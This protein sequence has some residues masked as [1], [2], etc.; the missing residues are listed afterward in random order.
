MFKLDK[1]QKIYTFKSK[2]LKKIK[3]KEKYG[4][5]FKWQQKDQEKI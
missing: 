4:G 5:V 2:D 1:K 3:S